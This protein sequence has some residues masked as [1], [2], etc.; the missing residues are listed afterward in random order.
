MAADVTAELDLELAKFSAKLKEAR[1]KARSEGGMIGGELMRSV[2]SGIAAAGA[3]L[4]TAFAAAL[5]PAAA[6]AAAGIVT[7]VKGAM[8]QERLDMSFNVLSGG[9]G[10]EIFDD[11]REKSERTGVEVG[12]MA[13]TVRKFLAMDMPVDEALKLQSAIL[14]ISGAVGLSASESNLLGVA[15]AQVAAKGVASMEELRQQIAE[16]G[17]PVFDALAQK[18]G[19]SNQE[20]YKMVAAGKVSSSQVIDLFANLEGS[21]AKFRGGADRM[22][23]TLA[24]QFSIVARIFDDLMRVMGEPIRDALKPLLQGVIEMTDGL[25]EK[26]RAVG[27]GIA[28]AIQYLAAAFQELS[29]GEMVDALKTGLVLAFKEGVNALI[30]G[31]LNG[32]DL[33][34][35]GMGDA[36]DF[37][38]AKL[39]PGIQSA[40]KYIEIGAMD[41]SAKIAKG[42][43]VFMG[44][45]VRE[46]DVDL[47]PGVE[48]MVG[49]LEAGAA[50]M[51][52]DVALAAKDM[53]EVI[54]RAK[55][56]FNSTAL[57][58][59]M[60]QRVF[61][62]REERAE[63]EALLQRLGEKVRANADAAKDAATSAD[64][65]GSAAAGGNA[66]S[67]KGAFAPGALAAAVNLLA[68]RTM[69]QLIIEEQQRGNA[70][71]GSIDSTL[72]AIRGEKPKPQSIKIEPVFA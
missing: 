58:Q 63:W 4:A 15:L 68:G 50:M 27:E 66:A 49:K 21:F 7:A 53:A 51:E 46:F 69:N 22:A 20:L 26:A 23:S 13:N 9:R 3:V 62:T 59:M 56:E 18:L 42:F 2:G 12:D 1:A 35:R 41:F 52:T 10:T 71:L 40:M 67:G 65:G 33:F 25:A 70:L 34:A 17:V 28:S 44:G 37:A 31:L 24:G 11:L 43:A 61:D 16:K 38:I 8:E 5:V 39:Q 19:V 47:I 30:P 64:G 54:R 29:G 57:T 6:G 60:N 45:L 36:M 55:E 14:D 72:K 32:V 48:G